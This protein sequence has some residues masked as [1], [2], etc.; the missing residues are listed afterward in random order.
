M[1]LAHAGLGVALGIGYG[2]GVDHQYL[3]IPDDLDCWQYVRV[4]ICLRVLRR[5][6]LF[7]VQWHM[8]VHRGLA[9][10][11]SCR[12]DACELLSALDLREI[13][14]GTVSASPPG[15]GVAVCRLDADRRPVRVPL[16]LAEPLAL[17]PLTSG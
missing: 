14:R 3:D 5:L 13:P 6:Y 7:F 9:G 16:A 17:S 4:V 11:E 15:V 1:A 10:M 12:S 8:V 2:I